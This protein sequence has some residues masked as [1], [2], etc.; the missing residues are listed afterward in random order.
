[1]P[2]LLS[3]IS[4]KLT[5]TT[6]IVP[7]VMLVTTSSTVPAS[8]PPPTMLNPLMVVAAN[9]TGPTESVLSAP[10][11][12]TSMLLVS[13]SLLPINAE[14]LMLLPV[15]ALGAIEAT[16]SL[17]VVVLFLDFPPFLTKAA[18]SGTGPITLAMF[19]LSDGFLMLRDTALLLMTTALSGTTLL[20]V[21]PATLAMTSLKEFVCSLNLTTPPPLIR[22]VTSGIT[23]SA[24]NVLTTGLL[25]WMV[26]VN[27]SL[28]LAKHIRASHALA[29][30]M[31]MS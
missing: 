18:K 22:A 11:D 1:M 3:L 30:S 5:T 2:A 10:M 29:V 27:K 19:V 7:A 4:A 26:S 15:P 21:Q 25:M 20:S 12:G 24:S 14:P 31:V 9:G 13:V 17:T 28:T 6:L 16:K 23:E 8:F